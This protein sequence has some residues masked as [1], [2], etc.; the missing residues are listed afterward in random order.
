MTRTI[1]KA[2]A[3]ITDGNRLLVFRHPN[4][5]EAGIQVPAGTMEEGETPEEAVMREAEEESGLTGLTL[6]S[7][8]AVVSFDGRPVLGEIHERYFF[9]LRC[10]GEVAETWRHFEM[11]ASDGS[12][13]ISFDFFW[14]HLPDGVPDLVAQHDACL[15]QL[16]ASLHRLAE[17]DAGV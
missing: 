16:L 8:L 9:H 14:A 17:P 12:P 7:S 10:N 1:R 4:N 15:P 3:Y 13:P 6:V 11:H 2:F 5:P